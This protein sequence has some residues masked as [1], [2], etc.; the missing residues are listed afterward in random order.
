M[1]AVVFTI[2][3]N[4]PILWWVVRHV[5]HVELGL[6]AFGMVDENAAHLDTPPSYGKFVYSIYIEG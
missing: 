4:I 1:S 5:G 3:L 6:L 2:V